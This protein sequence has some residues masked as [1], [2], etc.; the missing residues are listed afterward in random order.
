MKNLNETS[1][2]SIATGI[3]IIIGGSIERAKKPEVKTQRQVLD[4]LIS[5]SVTE[6]AFFKKQQQIDRVLGK[7]KL[8]KNKRNPKTLQEKYGFLLEQWINKYD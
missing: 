1:A 7:P 8:D 4:L 5:K 6:S 3:P 2:G